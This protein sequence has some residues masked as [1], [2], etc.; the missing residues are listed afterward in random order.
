MPRM[1]IFINNV[2]CSSYVGAQNKFNVGRMIINGEV[3]NLPEYTILKYVF[4]MYI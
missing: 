3:I 4:T 2:V 1:L